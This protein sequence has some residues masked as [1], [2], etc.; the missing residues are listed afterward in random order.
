[1]INDLAGPNSENNLIKN[2]QIEAC[3]LTRASIKALD[4]NASFNRSCKPIKHA[5]IKSLLM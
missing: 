2:A 4:S 3:N 5:L 1:M